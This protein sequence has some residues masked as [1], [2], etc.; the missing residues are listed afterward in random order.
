MEGRRE[1]ERETGIEIWLRPTHMSFRSQEVERRF[2]GEAK[3][4]KVLAFFFFFFFK[5]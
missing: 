1:R 4:K 5:Y 2:V 3:L